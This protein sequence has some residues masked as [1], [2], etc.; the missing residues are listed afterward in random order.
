MSRASEG[1][2]T[3]MVSYRIARFMSKAKPLAYNQRMPKSLL[4]KKIHC[5]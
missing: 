2:G 3:E 1:G 4:Q 5:L